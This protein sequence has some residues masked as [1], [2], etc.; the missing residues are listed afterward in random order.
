MIDFF[1]KA[2]MEALDTE[3]CIVVDETHRHRRHPG[4]KPGLY[5]IAVSIRSPLFR[6]KG[7]LERHRMIYAVL[8]PWMKSHLHAVKVELAGSI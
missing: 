2:L 3:D 6:D 1:Q 5:H 8:D 7:L 4:F